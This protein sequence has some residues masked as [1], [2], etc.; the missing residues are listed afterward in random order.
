MEASTIIP[1]HNRPER[2]IRAIQSVENQ[3]GGVTEVVVVNDGSDCDYSS[4][5]AHLNDSSLETHYIET[6]GVGA[7]AARN[8]GAEATSGDVLM[9]L[10]DDDRWRAK[11]A[12]RQLAL[13]DDDVVL[14][15]SGRVAVDNQGTERY[16]IDSDPTGDFST[17]ILIKNK[18]GT[19]SGVAVRRSVFDH[20]NGFDAEMSG[21]QDWELWIRLLPYGEVRYDPAYMIEWTKHDDPSDQMT[22]AYERYIEA[23]DRIR[24]KH[25]EKYRRLSWIERRKA[26][27]SQYQSIGSKAANC[28]S[29][30][31]YP[32]IARSLLQW[33]TVSAGS[34]LLPQPV[35][36]RLRSTFSSLSSSRL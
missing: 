10:D 2:A 21:C 6:D 28:G 24:A 31:K 5:R 20:V 27:A 18:I 15:Y 23:M 17:E 11:K 30:A 19:T 36:E 32:Y 25:Q 33:P 4:V 7:A 35:L 3:T 22:G 1:T 26:R 29:V 16:R 12:E 14:V 34:R 9:F 13:F 8:L